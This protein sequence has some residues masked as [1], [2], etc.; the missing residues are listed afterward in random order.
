MRLIVSAA[1]QQDITE[2]AI[3]IEERGGSREVARNFVSR[4]REKCG[5]LASVPFA[6]GVPR[7]DLRAGLRSYAFYNYMLFYEFLD[8]RMHLLK[9]TEGHRNMEEL[10]Q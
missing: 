2:I 1:A 8:D 9:V 10:F 5:H 4:L 7:D 6:T 3:Y